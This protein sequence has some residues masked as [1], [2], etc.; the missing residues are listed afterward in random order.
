MSAD[1]S[2]TRDKN[3]H[4]KALYAMV[5]YNKILEAYIFPRTKLAQESSQQQ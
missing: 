4:L 2:Y 5:A 1:R 3:V